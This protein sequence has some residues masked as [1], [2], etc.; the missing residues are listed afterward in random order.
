MLKFE[1]KKKKFAVHSNLIEIVK[2]IKSLILSDHFYHICMVPG[3]SDNFALNR[4]HK[5]EV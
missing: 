4:K 1:K 5:E 2:S 3:S